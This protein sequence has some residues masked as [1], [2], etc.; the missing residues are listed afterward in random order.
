MGDDINQMLAATAFNLKKLM[1]QLQMFLRF[2][3]YFIFKEPMGRI[4][5]L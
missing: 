3:L 5:P 2:L 4:A 1:R